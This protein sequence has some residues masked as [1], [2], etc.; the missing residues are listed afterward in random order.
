[1]AKFIPCL[2]HAYTLLMYT[3]PGP[4]VMFQTGCALNRN[5]RE[6]GCA[7]QVHQSKR[8]IVG[9]ACHFSKKVALACCSKKAQLFLDPSERIVSSSAQTWNWM[10]LFTNDLSTQRSRLLFT[11]PLLTVIDPRRSRV[12]FLRAA[13]P[14]RSQHNG[15]RTPGAWPRHRP[16]LGPCLP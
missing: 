14:R 16:I 8:R 5:P 15:P 6:T 1:M 2:G 4:Q 9:K 10:V 13:D 3:R 7:R 11:W 12:V